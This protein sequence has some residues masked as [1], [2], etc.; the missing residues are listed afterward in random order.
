MVLDLWIVAHPIRLVH[1]YWPLSVGVTYA[2]FNLLYY[3][4]GGTDRLGREYIYA[5]L[6]WSKPGRALLFSAGCLVFIML[7][8][9]IVWLMYLGRNRTTRI[10]R[11]RAIAEL[12]L[13]NDGQSNWKQQ[14]PLRR[15]EEDLTLGL[16]SDEQN[17]WK[18]DQVPI[19]IPD[20]EER[21]N[22]V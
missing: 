19:K 1:F 9:T 6:N 13:F 11:R 21:L 8:H 16:F 15:E 14:V 5:A 17:S 7:V 2:L 18:P 12:G 3:M 22:K 10:L 4:L 20:E